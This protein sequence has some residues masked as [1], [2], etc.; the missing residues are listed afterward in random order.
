MVVASALI[1]IALIFLIKY[2]WTKRN[3][4]KIV[5]KIPFNDFKYDLKTLYEYA[6]ADGKTIYKFAFE[7]IKNTNNLRT[8]FLGT[9]RLLVPQTPDDIKA[10]LTSKNCLEKSI[11]SKFINLEEG[12]LFGSVEAWHRHRKILDPYF[13]IVGVKNLISMFNDKSLTLTR[14]LGKYLNKNDFD[15]FHDLSALTLESVLYVMEHDI[16]LQNMEEEERDIPI[17]A[18]E[19]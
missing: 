1:F 17:K 3:I 11:F 5:Y 14:N 7:A 2:L 6:T 9:T 18:L 8:S 16:D 4:I 12:S 15:I 19:K 13:G 10:V